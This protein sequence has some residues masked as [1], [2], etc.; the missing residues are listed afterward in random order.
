M[1]TALKLMV[2]V[3]A[4]M[5]V[6]TVLARP[7]SAYYDLGT[8]KKAR[9][10]KPGD[11]QLRRLAE[12]N[13]R[14][15]SELEAAKERTRKARKDL[16]ELRRKL[17]YLRNTLALREKLYSSKPEKR[18]ETRHARKSSPKANSRGDLETLVSP[19]CTPVECEPEPVSKP[20]ET[21][22][23]TEHP[24]ILSRLLQNE[25]VRRVKNLIE[26]MVMRHFPPQTQSC[27]PQPDVKDAAPK[28]Q[29][30]ASEEGLKPLR[31]RISALKNRLKSATRTAPAG[32]KVESPKAT[33]D[34]SSAPRVP[35]KLRDKLLEGLRDK[36]RT[37]LDKKL[38]EM[39]R[40]VRTKKR[41]SAWF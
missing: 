4:A 22:S 6:V 28:A 12:E 18:D 30:P 41:R 2:L 15:K 38:K 1:R 14:L 3:V 5:L 25:R 13:E 19:V 34:K 16:R 10:S 36:F 23:E 37:E 20:E 33:S 40:E 27:T 35:E 21:T 32:E 8:R 17:G 39:K 7:A 31:E 29:K 11:E 26:E 24:C 9:V